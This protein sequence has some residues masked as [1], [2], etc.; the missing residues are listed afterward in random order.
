MRAVLTHGN[1]PRIMHTTAGQ[2]YP[3]PSPY[4]TCMLDNKVR[5]VG[6]R[7]A[8]VAAETRAPSPRRPLALIEVEYEV[9]EPRARPR[10]GGPAGAPVIHDEPDA[11]AVIPVPYE[12]QRNLAAADVGMPSATWRRPWPRAERI[13]ERHLPHPLRPALRPSS[14]TLPLLPRRRAA[15]W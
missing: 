10:G 5:Y 15:G 9:L 8:A 14:R 1:V 3:E 6:D 13:A 7:V 4:D 2:G 12:P 11:G